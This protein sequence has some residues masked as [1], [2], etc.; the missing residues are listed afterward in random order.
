MVDDFASVREAMSRYNGRGSYEERRLWFEEGSHALQRIEE[1][2]EAAQNALR[3]IAA[4]PCYL[5]VVDQDEPDP[6]MTSLGDGDCPSCFA[7]LALPVSSPARDP[8]A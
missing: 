7:A 8:N 6:R 3:E 4:L 5:D 1:Q 2:L